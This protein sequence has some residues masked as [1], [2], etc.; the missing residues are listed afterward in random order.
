[1]S[2]Y[3][4]TEDNISKAEVFLKNLSIFENLKEEEIHQI[5]QRVQ[6]KS[7]ASGVTIFHQE[8]P[9]MM[10]YMIETGWIRV[11]SIGRTGQELTLNVFGQYDIMGE[12]SVLDSKR[13]SGTS[14]TLAPTVVWLLP[15]N[16]VIDFCDKYPSI[17][18]VFLQ[19]L[20]DRVRST[21][22]SMEAMTFQDVQGRLAYKLLLLAERSSQ[23]SDEEHLIDIPLTQVD[24]ASIVGATRESVNKALSAL[25]AGK[26]IATNGSRFSII[27]PS[28]LRKLIQDRGR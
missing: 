5:A 3:S 26:Y 22:Q 23:F 24:L 6:R 2:L 4:E 15:K 12:L 27:N 19:I 16:D 9:G 17:T 1:M 25:R 11:Y 10:L 8:M 28:G 21:T 20:V 14:I 13:H 18:Q 7:F